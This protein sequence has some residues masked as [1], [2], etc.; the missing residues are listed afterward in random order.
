MNCVTHHICECK[1]ERLAALEKE[2][3]KLRRENERLNKMTGDVQ[4]MKQLFD[5]VQKAQDILAP[6]LDNERA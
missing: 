5:D 2:V 6:Y 1:A 3:K 4:Y